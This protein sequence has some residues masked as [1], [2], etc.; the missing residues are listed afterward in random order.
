[1]YMPT[2]SEVIKI[3][4]DGIE[5]ILEGDELESFLAQRKKDQAAVKAQIEAFEAQKAKRLAA[6]AKLQVLGLSE[7]EIKALGL[8]A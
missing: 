6:I 7:D 8:N 4:E 2:Q 5:R 1:M 3:T